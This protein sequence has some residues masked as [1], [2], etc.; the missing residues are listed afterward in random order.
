MDPVDRDRTPAAPTTR[1]AA[2]AAGAKLAAAALLAAAARPAASGAGPDGGRGG[3]RRLELPWDFVVLLS[4]RNE[5]DPRTGRPGAGDPEG[6]GVARV[7]LDPARGRVCWAIA[8]GGIGRVTAAH[9]HAGGCAENGPVVV[10]FRGR[11]RGCATVGPGLLAAIAADPGGYYV[12]V[13]TA[14][15]PGGAVRGQLGPCGGGPAA[16]RKK[17]GRR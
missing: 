13:H 4:G 1:R 8:V 7:D 16:R 3:G 14:E 9:I 12:N 6:R 15:Y 10:D 5:I 17:G 11:L 2:L